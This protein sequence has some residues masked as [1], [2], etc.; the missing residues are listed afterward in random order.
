MVVKV[1]SS[2][3]A[4]FLILLSLMSELGVSN[5][6]LKLFKEKKR[7]SLS[8]A[9]ISILV[10]LVSWFQD[11]QE[12][13]ELRVRHSAL[14]SRHEN[15]KEEL[16]SVQTKLD[17]SAMKIDSLQHKVDSLSSG[18]ALLRSLLMEKTQKIDFKQNQTIDGLK[19]NRD[20][21]DQI[22]KLAGARTIRLESRPMAVAILSQVPSRIAIVHSPPGS[23]ISGYA[24]ILK[25]ILIEAG[26]EV[27]EGMSQS[28][29]Q[30]VGVNLYFAGSDSLLT[31]AQYLQLALEVLG[32]EGNAYRVKFNSTGAPFELK[33]G[34]K[35]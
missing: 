14:V 10:L 5:R 3:L 29:P 25:S 35:P 34:V 22:G 11:S 16:D 19:Q 4:L 2:L 20:E 30:V 13:A 7:I 8:I 23:E 24:R 27:S 26:W 28:Y 9:I 33:V 31:T 32:V 6:W 21:I 18:T 12:N 17:G 1:I 15:T